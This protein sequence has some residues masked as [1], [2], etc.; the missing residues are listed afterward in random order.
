MA[1]GEHLNQ[2]A[3]QDAG[4]PTESSRRSSA[5]MKL[6]ALAGASTRLDLRYKLFHQRHFGKIIET[7]LGWTKR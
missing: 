4:S 6:S 7:V 2:S 3:H 1:E 5:I